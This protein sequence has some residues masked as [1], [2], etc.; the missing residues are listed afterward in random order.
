MF[1]LI[2]WDDTSFNTNASDIFTQLSHSFLSTPPLL[3]MY[4]IYRVSCYRVNP[5]IHRIGFLWNKCLPY[6]RFLLGEAVTWRR[7]FVNNFL[8]VPE[9]YNSFPAA[10][11]SKENSQKGVYKTSSPSKSPSYYCITNSSPPGHGCNEPLAPS[12][13][14]GELAITGSVAALAIGGAALLVKLLVEEGLVDLGRAARRCN[15]GL[16]A[17]VWGKEKM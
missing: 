10:Q 9:L 11:A 2:L 4:P 12:V 17:A 3:F 1:V 7:G 6:K 14:D 16:L 5:E 13:G 8:R 15:S